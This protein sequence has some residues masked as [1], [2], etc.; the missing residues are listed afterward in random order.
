MKAKELRISN[1]VHNSIENIDFQIEC[2][3]GSEWCTNICEYDYQEF[4]SK[5]EDLKPIPLTE[6][7]FLDFGLIQSFEDLKGC[8][9]DKFDMYIF[10]FSNNHEY[11]VFKS[12]YEEDLYLTSIKYIHE[13][14]N[15][16]FILIGE[17][18]TIK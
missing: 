6:E 16:Y 7:W 17:E 11:D 12:G 1:W 18:L 9:V 8:Y 4:D 5:I 10:T 13:L 14:Q 15:L 2:F 3:L